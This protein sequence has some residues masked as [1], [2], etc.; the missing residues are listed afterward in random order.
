MILELDHKGNII[1]SLQDPTGEM[2]SSVSSV[3]DTGD[4][5][6]LGSEDKNFIL[7]IGM[8]DRKVKKASKTVK[9]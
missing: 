1:Q 8:K 2:V 4:A 3:L 5:L 6:Y 7:K 9:A